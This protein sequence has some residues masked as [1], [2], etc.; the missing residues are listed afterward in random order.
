MRW[1]HSSVLTWVWTQSETET[2]LWCQFRTK[3]KGKGK[4]TC[5]EWMRVKCLCCHWSA[6][7]TIQSTQETGVTLMSSTLNSSTVSLCCQCTL[8]VCYRCVVSCLRCYAE[9]SGPRCDLD[10]LFVRP[11]DDPSGDGKSCW[12]CEAVCGPLTVIMSPA[13]PAGFSIARVARFVAVSHAAWSL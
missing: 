9:Y 6:G 11:R 13:A 10:A 3:V 5:R 2:G 8:Q 12:G 4:V 1:Q 7:V